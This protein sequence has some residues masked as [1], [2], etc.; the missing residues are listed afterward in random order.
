[1]TGLDHGLW[2][3]LGPMPLLWL[4]VTLVAYLVGPTSLTENSVISS[5]QPRQGDQTRPRTLVRSYFAAAQ[6]LS[7]PSTVRS[8]F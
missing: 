4:S 1:M 3:T 8:V 5:L 6:A 2:A 7:G